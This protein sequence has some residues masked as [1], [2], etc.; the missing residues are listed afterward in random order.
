MYTYSVFILFEIRNEIVQ[1]QENVIRIQYIQCV[2]ILLL[3]NEK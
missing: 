3:T 1:L 2:S